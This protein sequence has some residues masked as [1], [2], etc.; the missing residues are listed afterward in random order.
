MSEMRV[1]LDDRARG[2][3]VSRFIDSLLEG[4]RDLP[5]APELELASRFID[6]PPFSPSGR[7]AVAR[8][9]REMGANL[10]HGLHFETPDTDIP[11][12]TTVQD[13]IPLR[14]PASMPNPLKRR[15]F[16]A[17]ISSTVSRAGRLVV[18]SQLTRSHLVDLGC[19]ASKI[20]LVPLGASRRFSPLSAVEERIA[21]D[22]FG[23]H[24]GYFS[25]IMNP[26]PHKNIDILVEVANLLPSSHIVCAGENAPE[27]LRAVGRL[28]DD[29][30]RLFYGGS[31][32]FILPSLIEG[33][34]LPLLEARLCGI[35]VICGPEV[36]ATEIVQ[37]GVSIVDVRD[38]QAILQ[39]MQQISAT[40]PTME[41]LEP[42]ATWSIEDQAAGYL[43][44][45]GY[46][47]S[48]R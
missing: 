36:G 40:E 7:K 8:L 41:P 44:Q 35:P 43:D 3:G 11:T 16:K 48:R 5:G 18:P 22:R 30:L 25:A 13:L 14:H 29:D 46:V 27:P 32:A 24:G 33:F 9:A 31:K 20:A 38:P 10:I 26:R 4:F 23:S 17:L 37:Q 39:A 34:G 47:T 12:V 6:K 45:Y 28:T 21:R 19:P 15:I 42:G 1:L 2:P